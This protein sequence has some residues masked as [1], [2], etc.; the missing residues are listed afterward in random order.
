V[1]IRDRV[2]FLKGRL[3]IQSAPGAGT[4]LMTQIPIRSEANAA[5]RIRSV[6]N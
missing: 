2:S 4:Q 5:S 1:N 3:E 6:P